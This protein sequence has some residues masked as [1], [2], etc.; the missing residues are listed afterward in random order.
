[1][2]DSKRLKPYASSG[3]RSRGIKDALKRKS[4]KSRR[5]SSHLRFADGPLLCK[6]PDVP[7]LLRKER[8]R[9]EVIAPPPQPTSAGVT[10]G[11]TCPAS[12]AC[13]YGGCLYYN[14]YINKVDSVTPSNCFVISKLI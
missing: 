2:S 14:P 4:L 11:L 13:A 9:L 3:T 1:M 5:T 7:F 8:A 12:S 6:N 10:G